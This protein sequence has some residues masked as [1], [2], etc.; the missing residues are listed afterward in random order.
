MESLEAVSS[1]R[2]EFSKALLQRAKK[3]RNPELQKN[4]SELA[5][6]SAFSSLEGML[7]YVFEHFSGS[8]NFDVFEKSIIQE[9]GI[10]LQKGVPTL[11]DRRFHSIEDRIQFLFWRFS[12]APFD[13]TKKWWP[14]F[15]NSVSIRN[16]IMHPKKEF[17]M[18][19]DDAERAVSSVLQ[20]I[21]DLMVTVFKKNW[22]RANKGLQVVYSI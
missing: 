14:E 22:P 8:Q 19:I 12:G 10:R 4:F 9:K 1:R 5:V 3:E 11:V 13:N 16:E 2:F 17:E 15:L 6:V 7:S 21:D 18:S 20:V